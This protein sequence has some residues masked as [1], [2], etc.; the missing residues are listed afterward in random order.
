MKVMILGATGMLGHTMARVL[1][2]ES[3]PHDLVLVSRSFDLRPMFPELAD[4]TS[5]TGVDVENMDAL[6]ALFAEHRPDVV[7]NCVGLVKQ[8]STAE[9]PLVALPINAMLPLRLERL[10]EATG[11]RLIHVSTDCVFRGTKG[12]Y[13]ET[14]LP[15][16]TD[17]YGKSKQ[18]GEAKG[19]K[20]ITLR[21]SIIGHELNGRAQG[22][23]GWFLS[24]SGTVRGFSKAVFSGFPTV[25]LAKIIRDKVLPRPDL[26]GLYQVASAPINKHDLLQIVAQTYGHDIVIEHDD[27][28]IIDRS[29]DGSRFNKET[30]YVA[31]EWPELVSRMQRFR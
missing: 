7:V 19:P 27:K 23:I 6:I 13:S 21:T 29:L 22:L 24:Q 5:V 17:V 31:P 20:A 28:L 10:C 14:D 3:D 1:A 9:D 12:M 4:T 30:G 25:E 11:A 16:A 2:T 8:R 18:M 15:D 26:S